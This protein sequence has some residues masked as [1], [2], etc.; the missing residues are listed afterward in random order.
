MHTCRALLAL[1]L[2]STAAAR[3]QEVE[4]LIARPLTLPRGRVDLTLHGTYTNWASGAGGLIPTSL[5]GESL[6]L[7]VDFGASDRVQPGLAIALP[8][9]PG[10]GFGSV[11]GSIALATGPTSAMRLDAG[12]ERFGFNGNG[13]AGFNHVNRFFGGLGAA[14]K[15]PIGPTVAFL[16]GRVGAVHFGHFANVG[17]NGTGLYLGSSFLPETSSDFFVVSGGDNNGPTNIGINLPAGVLFQ[18][19]PHLAV[20]LQAGYSV[21]IVIPKSGSTSALHFIPVGMEAVLTPN[22]LVDIGLRF[23]LDGYVAESGPGGF[24]R[25]SYFDMRQLML[26]LRIHA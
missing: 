25:T 9:D 20:T 12:Y 21:A 17:D 13:T 19:D 10:A 16:S 23:F 8:I 6:A 5:A 14:I 4:P 24:D 2:C 1:L 3:A 11:L 7:G 22:R 26:W 15:H 18:P